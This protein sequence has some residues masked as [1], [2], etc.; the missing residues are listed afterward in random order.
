ME[1]LC[2]FHP[3]YDFVNYKFYINWC[4]LLKHH[5]VFDQ[6]KKI[7]LI[8]I[9]IVGNDNNQLFKKT[10]I[11]QQLLMSSNFF[12]KKIVS[13]SSG[14]IIAFFIKLFTSKNNSCSLY[15]FPKCPVT[16]ENVHNYFCGMWFTGRNCN[17]FK[18]SLLLNLFLSL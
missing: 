13:F 17:D 2:C 6:F 12:S 8:F 10:I 15:A 16:N 1:S 9:K 7:V 11:F 3:V 5:P 4:I 14:S 18:I